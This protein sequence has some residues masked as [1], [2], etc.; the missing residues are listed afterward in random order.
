MLSKNKIK[1]IRSLENKKFREKENLFLIEGEKL[2]EE[3]LLS[4]LN[5]QGIFATDQWIDK[6]AQAINKFS[7]IVE[8][9]TPNE[10]ER[11]SLLKSPSPVVGLAEI[12]SFQL[13]KKSLENKLTLVLDS[14]QDPGNL[15]TI[16]RIA[17]WF[18]IENI[19]CSEDSVDVYNPKVVQST[20]GAI[21]RVKTH[22]MPLEE[23]FSMNK[24]LQLPV[25]GTLLDGDNIYDKKLSQSGLIIMGNESKGINPIYQQF[26]TDKLFIPFYPEGQK[27]SES[28]N[29]GIATA[30]VC[31]EFRR[32][33]AR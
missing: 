14:V 5:I 11:I 6:N 15:G 29:V 3:L 33:A 1:L 9:V 22:Y 31:A 32:Q 18:G 30:I 12:P 24:D 26:I 17:D 23:L 20:M 4:G 7:N 27:R 25:Y 10:I 8:S 21:F 13:K 28:L 16:I 2:I 19:I